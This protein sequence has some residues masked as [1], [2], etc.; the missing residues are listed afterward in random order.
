M[1]TSDR[2]MAVKRLGLCFNCLK[3]TNH[4]SI[5]CKASTCKLCGKKHNTLLHHSQGGT[6]QKSSGQQKQHSA[7]DHTK[8]TVVSTSQVTQRSNTRVLL[9][10]AEVVLLDSRGSPHFCRALLDSGSQSNFITEKLAQTLGLKRTRIHSKISGIAQVSTRAAQVIHCRLKSRY[11]NYS[12]TEDFVIL[13]KIT[14]QLPSEPIDLS[15]LNIPD[16]LTMADPNFHEPGDIDLL[17]GAGLFFNILCYGK[18][19]T[20]EEPLVIQNTLL[21]WV[22]SG[23]FQTSHSSQITCN[24]SLEEN[25]DKQLQRFWQIEECLEPVKRTQSEIEKHFQETY[26]EFQQVG[27]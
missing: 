3:K 18:I 19:M 16:N 14:H 12:T 4:T 27:L 22:V 9:S 20:P 11:T 5:Q 21:G 2:E 8:H 25:L 1:C 26:T 23:K 13:P 17:I 7:V 15:K 6:I 10:T 24:V